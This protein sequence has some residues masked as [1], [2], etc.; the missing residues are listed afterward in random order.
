VHWRELLRGV[1]LAALEERAMFADVDS[2][3]TPVVETVDVHTPVR[4]HGAMRDASRPD[5][6]RQISQL[7]AERFV[8]PLPPVIARDEND[9]VAETAQP[10]ETATR[11]ETAAS[12]MPT[13][14]SEPAATRESAPPRA[15]AMAAA[16]QCSIDRLSG[17]HVGTIH[18]ATGDCRAD[19]APPSTTPLISPTFATPN[20]APDARST[21]EK[22]DAMDAVSP[23]ETVPSDR[24]STPANLAAPTSAPPATEVPAQ[25]PATP[26]EDVRTQREV[27]PRSPSVESHTRDAANPVHPRR[28]APH[29]P[30]VAVRQDR[31]SP[32]TP[33]SARTDAVEPKPEPAMLPAELSASVES[34]SI[35][36][37]SEPVAAPPSEPG[38]APPSESRIAPSGESG[39]APP[40]AEIARASD[41]DDSLITNI[42][43]RG[44][45]PPPRRA[46]VVEPD[47]SANIPVAQPASTTKTDAISDGRPAVVPS[48]HEA[49]SP[50]LAPPAQRDVK[51]EATPLVEKRSAPPT[52]AS[53]GIR[54]TEERRSRR[55]RPAAPSEPTQQ[56]QATAPKSAKPD[57]A[58]TPKDDAAEAAERS[59]VDWRRLLFEATS[60]PKQRSAPAASAAERGSEPVRPAT[61]PTKQP[62]RSRR[63]ADRNGTVAGVHASVF[64]PAYRD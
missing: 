59:M 51:Q 15:R 9:S 64:A 62:P 52:N 14:I 8:A 10:S 28:T 7:R 44:T 24:V 41:V 43:P 12:I 17:A 23:V 33:T 26:R 63:Q 11:A 34:A 37:A 54:P 49:I 55:S 29:V 38:I 22:P 39:I 27:P 4:T 50:E 53:S 47:S 21:R 3:A 60:D 32:Q 56:R 36:P 48:A 57:E 42:E 25:R 6:S 20:T 45:E 19:A 30:P 16:K 35:T 13:S 40:T 2:D 46:L 58:S 31:V 61:T 18:V 1:P 5:E